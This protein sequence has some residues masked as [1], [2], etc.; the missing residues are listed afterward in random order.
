SITK[1]RPSRSCPPRR[2]R[3]RRSLACHDDRMQ[4]SAQRS[5]MA[6]ERVAPDERSM[7]A[8]YRAH[9]GRIYA[10][11]LRPPD[12]TADADDVLQETFLRAWRAADSFRGEAAPG[13]WLC[14]IAI[15]ASRDPF[16]RRRA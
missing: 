12:S 6:D 10:L 7:R 8:L 5:W 1:R 4:V 9:S 11:A 16:R 2:T 13:T 15:N 3:G 14:R